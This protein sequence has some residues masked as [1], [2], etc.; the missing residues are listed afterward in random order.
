MLL[1][2]YDYGSCELLKSV[3]YFSSIELQPFD[4]KKDDYNIFNGCDL[5]TS[6]GVDYALS[7][8]DILKLFNSSSDLG[9]FPIRNLISI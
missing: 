3:S 1:T 7:D 4:A 5:L 9:K 6:W 2:D 8:E